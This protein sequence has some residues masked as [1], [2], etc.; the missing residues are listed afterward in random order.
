ML[1][2][3]LLAEEERVSSLCLCVKKSSLTQSHQEHGEVA[4][5]SFKVVVVLGSVN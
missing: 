1:Q 3:V 5:R 2:D 4:H